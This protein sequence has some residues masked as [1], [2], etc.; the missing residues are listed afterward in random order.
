[1]YRGQSSN[2]LNYFCLMF[3][4]QGTF[5]AVIL[6]RIDFTSN[7][8]RKG[9]RI[10]ITF[11]QFWSHEED[12]EQFQHVQVSKQKELKMGTNNILTT[13]PKIVLAVMARHFNWSLPICKHERPPRFA[14]TT[15]ISNTTIYTADASITATPVLPPPSTFH[16]PSHLLSS[17]TPATLQL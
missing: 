5:R 14:D 16:S 15:A 8:F 11:T 1:M 10:Y 12:D 4:G 7:L 9:H 17:L 2:G 3:R 13:P 6:V